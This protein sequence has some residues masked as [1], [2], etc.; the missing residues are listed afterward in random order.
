MSAL[1][2]AIEMALQRIDMGRPEPAER[3]KPG[4][5]FLKR[6]RPEPVKAALRVHRGFDET[7]LPQ[8]AKVLRNGR[9]RHPKLT[10]DLSHGLL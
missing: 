4:I 6:L 10:L 3:S 7:G 2:H 8:D 5:H 9:L 1:I